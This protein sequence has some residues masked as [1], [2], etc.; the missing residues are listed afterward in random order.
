MR[1]AWMAGEFGQIARYSAKR[2]A[3]V[4]RLKLK[5]GIRVL[6]ALAGAGD[7]AIALEQARRREADESLPA[8]FEE[9]DAARLDCPDAHFDIAMRGFGA[10]SAPRSARAAGELAGIC[11]RA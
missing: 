7:L 1:G 10:M 11:R 3:F 8:V 5:P 9:G 4:D 2:E 6:D